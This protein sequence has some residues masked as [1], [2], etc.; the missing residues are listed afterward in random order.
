M[1]LLMGLLEA[2]ENSTGAAIR[3]LAECDTGWSLVER[4]M[5]EDG[6]IQLILSCNVPW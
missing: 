4:V 5:F 3:T 6:S 2:I 1:N